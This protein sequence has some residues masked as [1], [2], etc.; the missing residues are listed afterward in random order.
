MKIMTESR[1]EQCRNALEND[2]VNFALIMAMTDDELEQSMA[3]NE[4]G[5]YTHYMNYLAHKYDI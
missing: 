4:Y 3:I 2:N 5:E 1:R